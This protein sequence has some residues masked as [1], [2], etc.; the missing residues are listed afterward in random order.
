MSGSPGRAVVVGA[1][2]AGLL[3]AR[4]L[5]EVYPEVV[6][7]DRDELPDGPVARGGVPQMR[8]PHGLLAGGRDALEELLPGITD[9]LVAQGAEAGDVQRMARFY[10]GTR[11]A[12]AG[13]SGLTSVAVSRPLLE[14]TIR[15]RVGATSGVVFRDRCSV[16]DLVF[17]ADLSR[18]TGLVVS[19]PDRPGSPRTVDA[20]LVVDASGRMSRTP[21]WLERRGFQPPEEERVR[22]DIR[23]VT[24]RF[25]RR[26]G[27][28]DGAFMVLVLASPRTPRSGLLI[29]Q[30]GGA[31]T[32][33]LAGYHGVRPPTEL[34]DFIAYAGTLESSALATLLDGLEP[35]G[36]GYA[37]RFQA[38]VRRRYERLTRMPAGLLV[39]G[40]ALASFDPAFGQGMT[41]A[42]LEARVLRDSVR[43]GRPVL[44]S[45]FFVEASRSV[46]T[47]WQISVGGMP[48][49]PGDASRKRLPDRLVGAYVGA[50][51]RAG[52]D[53]PALAT[54]FIKVSHMT[55]PPLSLF[56]PRQVARVLHWS[57]R[58][59]LHTPAVTAPPPTEPPSPHG[60]VS[61]NTVNR[62]GVIS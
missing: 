22:C 57:V 26:P 49:A 60:S 25:Q 2:I 48:P 42:A 43:T 15:R 51:R 41:T 52:C 28:A 32:A 55:A 50:V 36:D 61:T 33:S 34:S 53:D 23:Y 1:S 14:W 10:T 9:E 20:G 47:S 62:Q 17:S 21:E 5:S 46:D 30:E 27:D 38:S 4:A 31:W 8:H 24:R 11:P 40:D 13:D 35:I 37:Y 39:I 58:S 12:A 7:L 56:R 45:R 44:A 19:S 3:A 29:A 54:A 59:A 6:V 18:I 16:L